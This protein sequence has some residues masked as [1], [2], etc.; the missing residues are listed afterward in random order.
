MESFKAR[1]VKAFIWDFLGRIIIQTSGFI[2]T[3]FLARILT[4]EDF[5]LIAIVMVIIGIAQVFT[6]AGL[7]V[8]LIQRRHVHNIHYTSV[9]YFNILLGIS[10]TFIMYIF[11]PNIAA[12]YEYE[13][14]TPLLHVIA[15]FFIIN[16]LGAIQS[17][18]FRKELNFKAI[19]KV[20]LTSSIIGGVVGIVL[21]TYG[22]GIWSLVVNI[23]LSQ[24]LYTILIWR[25]SEWYPSMN[26]SFK[27]LKQLWNFGFKIFLSKILDTAFSRLDIL[28]FAKILPAETIG[29]YQRAKSLNSMVIRY[30]SGSLMAVLFP[31][32]STIQ[33]DL[34]YFQAIVL[35][36]LN[37]LS[38]VVFL[39]IGSLYLVS[40]ELIVLLYTEKWLKSVE[41]LQVL[42]LS[43]FAFPLSALLVNVLSSRGNSKD[44]LYLEVYKKTL[45]GLNLSIGYFF[46]LEVFLYG[47]IIQALIAVYINILY[48]AKEILLP[49]TKFLFPIIQ[50][51]LIAIITTL[52]VQY[53]SIFIAYTG[54]LMF[55][56]KLFAYFSMY[57]LLSKIS[58]STGY[59][60]VAKEIKTLI[61]NVF[62]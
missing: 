22:A 57:I 37:A 8:A 40:E 56:I 26:F 53:L 59:K 5:G 58:N 44:F 18:R 38:F 1:G 42:L 31:L 23:L 33:N 11:A 13:I 3:I 9:F 54:I 10:F 45:F 62:I 16:T 61:K 15:F 14:L 49:I 41:Y 7:G 60:I 34:K 46:G 51:V 17:I 47:L 43:S 2:I 4:P 21:A 6:D 19:T 20:S 29:F 55:L 39:I 25:K 12:Y 27:A 32:L 35:K 28:I 36:A 30:S 48:A 52:I 24:I 50:H